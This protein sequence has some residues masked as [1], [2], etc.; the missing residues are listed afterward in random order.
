[1]IIKLFDDLSNKCLHFPDKIIENENIT[2][3]EKKRAKLIILRLVGKKEEYI[4]NLDNFWLQHLINATVIA[5]R[6][7]HCVDAIE[8]LIDKMEKDIN[9]NYFPAYNFIFMGA[10]ATNGVFTS[11][12]M[13][14]ISQLIF[15]RH[16]DDLTEMEERK[17]Y[18]FLVLIREIFA[19]SQLIKT[20]LYLNG[21]LYITNLYNIID[22]FNDLFRTL[23]KTPI[24]DI[25]E[26]LEPH[27][28]ARNSIA[29]AHFVVNYPENIPK[30]DPVQLIPKL[31]KWDWDHSR[32]E[33]FVEGYF[34]DFY[35]ISVEDIRKDLI[36]LNVFICQYLL[37]FQ[38]LKQ[39]L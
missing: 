34:E 10:T 15:R 2:E 30:N 23:F 24:F 38:Y 35:D 19:V 4:E 20:D 37:F 8:Y 11:S 32:R 27:K 36:C 3:V 33:Y 7:R 9:P 28:N 25:Y 16:R 12:Q 18:S 29:H 17:C 13:E 26:V 14:V 1:V 31:V 22:K 5:Y 39:I 6:R 21:S